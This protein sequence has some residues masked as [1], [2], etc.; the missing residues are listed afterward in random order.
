MIITLF[1]YTHRDTQT[2]IPTHTHNPYPS[3]WSDLLWPAGHLA[4][5]DVPP[6]DIPVVQLPGTLHLENLAEELA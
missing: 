3:L 2:L 1:I 6:I 4:P 5:G